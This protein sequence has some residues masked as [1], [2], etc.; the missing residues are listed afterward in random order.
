MADRF[1]EVSLD[2]LLNCNYSARLSELTCMC[3]WFLTS[4]LNLQTVSLGTRAL[5]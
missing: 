4:P 2:V 3:M 1:N 5:H